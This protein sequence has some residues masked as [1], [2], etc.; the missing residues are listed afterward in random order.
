[1]KITRSVQKVFFCEHNDAPSKRLSHA[2]MDAPKEV[3]VSVGSTP[4]AIKRDEALLPFYFSLGDT[5]KYLGKPNSE[6]QIQTMLSQFFAPTQH[7]LTG[8]EHWVTKE[9]LLKVQEVSLL[10]F[11]SPRSS[12][13]LA[14]LINRVPLRWLCIHS[15]RLS[16]CF[17]NRRNQQL[18]L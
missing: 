1:M 4:F 10:P 18:Q 16:K 2:M 9:G 15:S 13:C 6:A 3:R 8:T 14:P 11:T 5:L 12:S 7:R 17:Y